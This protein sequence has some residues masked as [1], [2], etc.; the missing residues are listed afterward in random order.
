MILKEPIYKKEPHGRPGDGICG[1]LCPCFDRLGCALGLLVGVYSWLLLLAL[2]VWLVWLVREVKRHAVALLV[3][4]AAQM[5][6]RG[7]RYVNN[8]GKNPST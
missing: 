6:I 1:G 5:E 8:P 2:L 4:P 7:Q 3:P